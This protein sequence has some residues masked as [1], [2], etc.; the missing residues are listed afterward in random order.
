MQART[1]VTLTTNIPDDAAWDDNDELAVPGGH[2]LISAIHD[3][4]AASTESCELPCQRSFYGWEFTFRNRGARFI[5]VV[6]ATEAWLVICEP[7]GKTDVPMTTIVLELL[8][9][10]FAN[11]RRFNDVRWHFRQDYEKGDESKGANAPV[12]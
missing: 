1:H 9:R 5:I 12:K 7:V 10:F 4:I 8:D 3:G 6:Q 11:D 2:A